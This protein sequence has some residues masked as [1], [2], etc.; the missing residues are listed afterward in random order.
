MNIKVFSTFILWYN[1]WVGPKDTEV[2]PE[3]RSTESC[4]T[5][6]LLNTWAVKYTGKILFHN[7]AMLRGEESG[8]LYTC[9]SVQGKAASMTKMG[10]KNSQ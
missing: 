3:Q 4:N 1:L 2:Q 10:R 6:Q 8:G 7:R 5:I 9:L